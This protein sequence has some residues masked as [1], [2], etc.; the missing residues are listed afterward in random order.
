[1]EATIAIISIAVIMALVGYFY[2]RGA[3]AESDINQCSVMSQYNY[4]E[5]AAKQEYV[6]THFSYFG[7]Q[8]QGSSLDECDIYL[9]SEKD[10]GLQT[11]SISDCD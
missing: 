2:I 6:R 3:I 9:V 10:M 7:C 11:S 5:L 8:D 4:A 1:M